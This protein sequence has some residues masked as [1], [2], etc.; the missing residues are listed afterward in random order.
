M[1]QY[2]GTAAEGISAEHV[3]LSES[4]EWYLMAVTLSLVLLV[5]FLAYNRFAKKT[6]I[7]PEPEGMSFFP[8]LIAQKWRIDE[9]YNALFE[10]PYAWF[11][12]MFSNVGERMVM[13]PIMN[14]SGRLANK[15]GQW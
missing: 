1:K 10:K 15:A 2:L 11:S 13:V 3:A 12:S 4:T 6:T 7:D 5:I 8:R 14:S 9:L